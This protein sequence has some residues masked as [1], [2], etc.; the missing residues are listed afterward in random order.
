MLAVKLLARFIE[1]FPANVAEDRRTVLRYPKRLH[2]ARRTQLA[3]VVH[4]VDES[5]FAFSALL[6]MPDCMT[7]NRWLFHPAENGHR[8]RKLV[9]PALRVVPKSKSRIVRDVVTW[10]LGRKLPTI[11]ENMPSI[12]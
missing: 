7:T 9:S 8:V 2:W 1:Q 4:E 6:V 10:D 5:F 11:V 12:G 3:A